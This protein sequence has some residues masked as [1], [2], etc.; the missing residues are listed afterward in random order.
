MLTRRVEIEEKEEG[1]TPGE[2][3]GNIGEKSGDGKIS[4]G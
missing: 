4:Q 3:N 2:D 1:K